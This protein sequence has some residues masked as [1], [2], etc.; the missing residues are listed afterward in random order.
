MKKEDL[1]TYA[2]YAL[3]LG[4]ALFVGLEIIAPAFS[5]L[6]IVGSA[7]YVYALITIGVGFIINATFLELGHICGALVGGYTIK[8]TNILG[9]SLYKDQNKWKFGMKSFEGLTGETIVLPKNSK[10]QPTLNLWGGLIFYVLEVILGFLLAYTLF[11]AEQWGR[12][13]VI[14][15]IAIGGMLMIYNFMPF[16]MD[17]ITDGY[18]LATTPKGKGNEVFNELTRIEQAYAK[19]E[20]LAPFKFFKELNNSNVQVLIHEIYDQITNKKFNDALANIQRIRVSTKLSESILNK[21]FSIEAYVLLISK[22]Q[23]ESSA[24]FYELSSRERKFISNDATLIT[25]SAYILIAGTI[26][27]SFSEAA[28]CYDRRLSGM[29]K[30]QDNNLL[31]LESSFFENSLNMVKE[32]H[33]DWVF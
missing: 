28:Y 6:G 15:I 24:W 1:Y 32:R 2:V 29:K 8:S 3:M 31:K 27:D 33:P 5:V 13:A 21:A 14:I 12:Y 4:L 9:F 20:K 26:E 11:T 10:S 19:K 22:S 7:Q 23:S 18:R 16:K 17:T 25:L 30:T